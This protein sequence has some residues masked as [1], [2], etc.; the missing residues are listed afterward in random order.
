MKRRVVTTLLLQLAPIA[1]SYVRVSCDQVQLV[2]SNKI[3]TLPTYYCKEPNWKVS[4]LLNN[5]YF[6]ALATLR[7]AWLLPKLRARVCV[8]VCVCV[9][10]V[11]AW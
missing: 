10:H 8:C 2:K 4:L 3:I 1:L 6:S 9:L 5:V 7:F 11:S